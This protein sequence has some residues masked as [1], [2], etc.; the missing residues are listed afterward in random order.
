MKKHKRLKH[1]KLL[2]T[3]AVLAV[4]VIA[5]VLLLRWVHT[6][7]LQ[8]M[9]PREYSDSVI[10]AKAKRARPEPGLR[11]HPAGKPVQFGREIRCR[12]HWADAAYP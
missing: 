8:K 4:L 2:I 5:A 12:R 1:K 3:I 11:R 10:E 6:R 7:M 9:Y